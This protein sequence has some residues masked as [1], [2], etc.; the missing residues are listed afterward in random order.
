MDRRYL[1]DFFL[2]LCRQSYQAF[3]VVILNDGYDDLAHFRSKY[4]NLNIVE[5]VYRGTIAENRQ[6]AINYVKQHFYDVVIFGD[7]DDYFSEN[8][9]EK[10]IQ[11]LDEN[12][13]VVND[14]SLFADT[15]VFEPAYI[16]H[17]VENNVQVDIQF[18]QNKNIFGLSNTALNLEIMDTVHL[19]AELIAVDWFLFMTLMM[20]RPIKALF[21]SDTQTYYRQ[22][23]DNTVG[24]KRLTQDAYEHGLSVKEIHYR[25]LSSLD[26]RYHKLWNE[27]KVLQKKNMSDQYIQ[28]LNANIDYPLWWENIK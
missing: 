2:S 28:M 9:V 6:H 12:D 27:I 5:I 15:G 25:L 22:Y 18:I 1:E 7:S 4:S 17:R 14:I 24:L 11:L 16:A 10:V 23:I 3:D 19:P 26:D 20:A 8:R 13:I 21:T